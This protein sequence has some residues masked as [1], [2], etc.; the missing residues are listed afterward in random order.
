MSARL[1]MMTKFFGSAPSILLCLVTIA[2]QA[3]DAPQPLK[4]GNAKQ[5]F[6]DDFI[7]DSNDG[8]TRVLHQPERYSGNPVIV[9]DTP[10]EKWQAAVDGRPVIYDHRAKEFKMYYV[11]ALLEGDAPTGFRY[12]TCYA[13]SKDGFQWTKPVLGQV[14]WEGSRGNNILKWGENWM[15]RP[16]VMEDFMTRIPRGVSR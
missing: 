15:R 12:K 11:S 14:E 13:V 8:L 4:I 16:N 1:A 3:Q 6:V 2:A 7:V 5:L 10:W 9:G